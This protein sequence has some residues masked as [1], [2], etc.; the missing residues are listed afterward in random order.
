MVSIRVCDDYPRHR[1]PFLVS[2]AHGASPILHPYVD[3][4]ARNHL[5][6]QTCNYP[7]TVSVQLG[8]ADLDAEARGNLGRP[9]LTYG[10]ST[11]RTPGDI[12][13]RS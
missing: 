9:S 1:P 11:R 8:D 12:G 4:H 10:Q 13:A 7:Y 5:H 3:H 6:P 2:P